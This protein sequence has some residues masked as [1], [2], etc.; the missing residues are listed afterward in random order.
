MGVDGTLYFGRGVLI[1]T[2]VLPGN[3]KSA[4]SNLFETIDVNFNEQ[5]FIGRLEDGIYVFWAAA[6]QKLF[7]PTHNKRGW[8]RPLVISGSMEISQLYSPV[9]GQP[10]NINSK[11][12][13]HGSYQDNIVIWD[14]AIGDNDERIILDN[15]KSRLLS[16]GALSGL[17]PLIDVIEIRLA[18]TILAY[19][20]S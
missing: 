19:I 7:T 8:R 15:V 3:W 12:I 6:P 20:T 18:G 2:S 16:S 4:I 1:N 9:P 17:L 10:I 14:V 13:W 5:E 11:D